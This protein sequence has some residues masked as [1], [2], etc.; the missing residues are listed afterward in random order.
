[1]LIIY[2]FDIILLVIVSLNNQSAFVQHVVLMFKFNLPLFYFSQL[3][4]F[5]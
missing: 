5:S 4:F 1:M 2:Y 3:K